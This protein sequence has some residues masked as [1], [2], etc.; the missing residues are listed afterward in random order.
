MEQASPEHPRVLL[1]LAVEGEPDEEQAA[2]VRAW[3][4]QLAASRAWHIPPPQLV[5]ELDRDGTCTLG[6]FTCLLS[7]IRPGTR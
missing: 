2:I 5:D 7:G 6:V 1:L 4:E 3:A